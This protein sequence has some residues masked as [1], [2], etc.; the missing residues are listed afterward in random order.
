MSADARA[1]AIAIMTGGTNQSQSNPVSNPT[2]VS[3]EEMSAVSSSSEPQE[4]QTNTN[5]SVSEDLA[6]PETTKAAPKEDPLSSQYA[7]LARKEK[8]LRA[9]SQAQDAALRQREEAI[10]AREAALSAKDQEYKTKYIPKDRLTQDP[11][12]TLQEN[13]ISYDQITQLALNPPAQQDPATKAA[14]QMLQDE[15]KALKDA[16]EKTSKIHEESQSNAYK[17]AVAQIRNEAKS[18]VSSSPEDFETI[19]A[20]G[21]VDD[22]VDL[23]EQ[24]FK[25]EG[26]LLT[27]EEAAKAVEEHLVEEAMKYARLKKIQQRL[28]PTTSSAPSKSPDGNNASKQ[29]QTLKTLTNAVGTSRQLSVRERA[30]LAFKGEKP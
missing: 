21:S 2:S 30:I 22:V 9:K 12:N 7:V 8:A 4:G 27:V 10:A 26:V 19:H 3:P 17:Q 6:A 29:P 23:I 11:W 28:T 18:L 15:I 13:G 1:R 16:Q 14:M 24:T 20:S 5:E 25:S